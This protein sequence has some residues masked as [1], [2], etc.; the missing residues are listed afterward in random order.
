[1]AYKKKTVLHKS[2][3]VLNLF[4]AD[5]GELTLEELAIRTHMNKTTTRRIAVSLI[6]CGLLKQPKKRGKYSLGL[7]LLDYSQALKKQ[8]PIVDIAQPLLQDFGR[9]VN[10]TTSMALWDGKTAVICQSIHPTHPLKVTS[11]EGT[12]LGLHYNSLGKA[13]LA[14]LKPEE[15]DNLLKGELFRFTANTITNVSELKNQLVTIHR[16]GI[17]ID[18]EEGFK[19]IRGIAAVFKNSEG[20]TVGAV[21]ILG[22]SVRLTRERIQ[23]IVPLL[24]ECTS[25]ISEALGYTAP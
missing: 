22:P 7:K 10:E 24:K 4:L 3:D 11:Y 6:D 14:E 12:L 5:E 13:I 23:E 9:A 16:E 19:G 25:R 2:V 21:T 8:L 15:Q 17:A 20:S 18:D 1:M